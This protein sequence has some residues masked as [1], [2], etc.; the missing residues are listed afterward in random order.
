MTDRERTEIKELMREVIKEEMGDRLKWVTRDELMK[1]TGRSADT[2]WRWKNSGK[3][4]FKRIGD[5]TMYQV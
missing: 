5:V 2:I 3:I 4:R 1:M